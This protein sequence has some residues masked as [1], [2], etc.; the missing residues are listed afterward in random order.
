MLASSIEPCP[1]PPQGCQIK[2][3]SNFKINFVNFPSNLLQRDDLNLTFE[4][5][6]KKVFD[7]KITQK[8]PPESINHF[9]EKFRDEFLMRSPRDEWNYPE[10]K[11][12]FFKSLL[13]PL[14][15]KR[16]PKRGQN[17][18]IGGGITLAI[19][20]AVSVRS[21]VHAVAFQGGQSTKVS[22]Q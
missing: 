16:N 12:I 4:A 7:R 1:P 3:I 5:G 2:S 9:I 17:Q 11:A 8:H 10:L 19:A 6:E 14:F 18:L 15:G 13:F 20:D 21:T 22:K